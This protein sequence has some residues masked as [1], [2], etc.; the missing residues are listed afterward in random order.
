MGPVGGIEAGGTKFVCGVGTGPDDLLSEQF[1]TEGPA[2]TM[3]RV[4]AFFK[5]HPR[6]A[7]VGVGSFGPLN[8]RTGWITTT[9]KL[10]WRHF[11]LA[12]TIRRVTGAAIV[13]DTDVNAAALAE[14]HWGAARGLDNFLYLTVG[15]GI[16][17]GGMMNGRLMHGLLHPEFGHIRVP[18][19][20]SADPF[21]GNCPSHNDCLEGLAS[22]AA[23]SARWGAP[24]TQLP[25]SHPAWELEAHYLALGLV[26]WICTLSPERIIAGGGVMRQHCLF[27]L[28]RTKVDALL[29]GYLEA[30]AIV[31]PDL[32]Q[33]A[34]VLGAIAL[35]LG[36]SQQG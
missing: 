19:D 33:R 11:D 5:K 27:P 22:G 26:N 30:P 24:G 21:P 6:V 4:A 14:H 9:P 23:I 18:H 29:N 16:G 1:P 2:S 25:P 28:I 12:D 7:V 35:A 20:F 31:P 36:R 8:L 32:G 17:G 34:G 10:N 13:L 3:E 15:T